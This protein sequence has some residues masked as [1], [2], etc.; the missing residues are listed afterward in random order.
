MSNKTKE[1]VAKKEPPIQEK[2]VKK[3]EQEPKKEVI[4]EP[5]DLVVEYPKNYT[6][7]KHYKDGHIIKGATP[8]L[9]ELL[10]KKGIAKRA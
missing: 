2:K 5:V 3:G 4:K 6:G 1:K 10:L 8:D 7:R 9:A